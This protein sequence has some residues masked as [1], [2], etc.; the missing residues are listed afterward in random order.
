MKINHTIPISYK[1]HTA[2]KNISHSNKKNQIKNSC[3]KITHKNVAIP[4]YKIKDINTAK[5][6]LE[7]TKN[8][9]LIQAQMA[10]MVQSNLIPQRILKILNDN[11]DTTYKVHSTK[12]TLLHFTK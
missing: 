6:T 12:K 9:I 10:L 7:F 1:N 5:Q 2:S 3:M 4:K 11:D 8:Q